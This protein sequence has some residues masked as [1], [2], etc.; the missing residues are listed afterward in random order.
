MDAKG[1]YSFNLSL[2]PGNSETKSHFYTYS[3]LVPRFL[4]S[5]IEAADT[6]LGRILH[7]W[8]FIF[9]K[10]ED[11]CAELKSCFA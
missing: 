7:D 3:R 6:S 10:P 9:W 2:Y 8:C 1:L 5:P 4:Y 11:V